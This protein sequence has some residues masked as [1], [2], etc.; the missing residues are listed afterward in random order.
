MEMYLQPSQI[1]KGTK[2]WSEEGGLLEQIQMQIW[3]NNLF[4]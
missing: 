4:Q 3:A 1:D 2:S